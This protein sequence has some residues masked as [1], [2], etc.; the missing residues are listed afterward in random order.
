MDD[1]PDDLA[2]FIAVVALTAFVLAL[3]FPGPV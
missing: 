2:V 1:G 3:I